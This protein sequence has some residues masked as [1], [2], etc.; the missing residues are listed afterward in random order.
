MTNDNVAARMRER[1]PLIVARDRYLSDEVND[2]L[3]RQTILMKTY[4]HPAIK[5]CI[6][7]SPECCRL[8]RLYT[9]TQR[10]RVLANDSTW[11]TEHTGGDVIV[12]VE[13]QLDDIQAHMEN[14]LMSMIEETDFF[15]R[16]GYLGRRI[17]RPTRIRP[18]TPIPI[19]VPTRTPTP[20]PGF[21]TVPI[22][23]LHLSDDD[24]I[25]AASDIAAE[26]AR[27]AANALGLQS[28]VLPVYD[29]NGVPRTRHIMEFDLDGRLIGEETQGV[30]E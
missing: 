20:Y 22:E 9:H 28:P 25:Q 21:E 29:S 4:F 12:D 19:P 5:E 1:Y 15:A 24:V 23:D 8:F 26:L 14:E 3:F 27:D 2:R 16:L 30:S 13:T 11:T 10:L 7:D 18:R 6:R 17:P